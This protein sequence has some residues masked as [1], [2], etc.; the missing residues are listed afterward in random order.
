MFPAD[1]H[2]R[3]LGWITLGG[4]SLGL[5]AGALF[6]RGFELS[7]EHVAIVDMAGVLGLALGYGIGYAAGSDNE[8]NPSS[9]ICSNGSCP[10]GA[11]FALGGMAIGLV[12][13]G[14][15]TR[16][17]KGDLPIQDALITTRDGH[18]RVGVPRLGFTF[19]PAPE[20]V[21]RRLSMEI[22]RGTF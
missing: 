21:D 2:D 11:R 9:F 15:L 14:I 16:H 6:A 10:S 5:V 18:L 19:A 17:Y 4:T 13:A 1:T 3:A 22:I 7:R 12:A 20:G 8:R